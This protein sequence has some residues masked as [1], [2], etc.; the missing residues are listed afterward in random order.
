MKIHLIT[1]N[2]NKLRE[3]QAIFPK[4]LGLTA[5]K[6]DLDEIQSL[7]LHKIVRHKLR[8]AYGLL[9][10]PVIIEDVSAELDNLGGLPGPFVKFFEERLGKGALYQLSQEGTKV[11]IRCT[12]GYFDGS[13]E[14]IVE[15]VLQGTITAPRG[16]EGFGFD[17]VIV[18]NGYTQTMSELGQETKNTI[19]HRFLAANHM[20]KYLSNKTL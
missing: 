16:D 9:H 17:F 14:H 13:T 6:L 2:P 15:G 8:Q 3:L 10:E 12:M 19:S 4:N 11:T 20:A 7:D 18:P 1:G 5:N